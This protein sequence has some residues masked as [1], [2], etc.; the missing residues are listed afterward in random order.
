MCFI[1]L[2]RNSQFWCIQIHCIQNQIHLVISLCLVL[3]MY[4]AIFSHPM[5]HWYPTL[6]ILFAVSQIIFWSYFIWRSPSYNALTRIWSYFFPF[7]FPTAI[8]P[9]CSYLLVSIAGLC[10][11]YC[12]GYI[13]LVVGNLTRQDGVRSL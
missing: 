5:M 3:F 1:L 6:S 7:C 2:N 11:F 4:I 12:I 9:K 10:K 13:N 8:E